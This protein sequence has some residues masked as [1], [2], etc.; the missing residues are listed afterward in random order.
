M[1]K[2]MPS[3]QTAGDK[4]AAKLSS[5]LYEDGKKKNKLYHC[6]T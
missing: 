5:C 6:N 3:V 2:E 4:E 1:I